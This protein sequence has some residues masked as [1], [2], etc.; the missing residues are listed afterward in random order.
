MHTASY[1]VSKE[2]GKVHCTLCP[3]ACVVV[4]G[5]YGK[6]RVRKNEDGVMLAESWGAVSGYHMDPIEK[7]PLYH[8][9]PGSQI[10]SVGSYGC[11]FRCPWCQNAGISQCGAET[12]MMRRELLPDEIIHT[13]ASSDSMGVA[14][15][16]NE[17]TVWF[18]FM[19]DIARPVKER[20]MKNVVV[21]NGF[22]NPAP[23]DE[24]LEVSDAFNV[25]LKSFD[26]EVYREYAKARLE[27]VLNTL[28]T[29]VAAGKHL[30]V[31]FL[32]VPGVNDDLERFEEMIKWLK[33][34][35]GKKVVLHVN[36]Y[37]PSWKMHAAPTPVKLMRRMKSIAGAHL[38]H[39]YLGNVPGEA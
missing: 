16:Y 7:K 14:Y 11:N 27:P 6:C 38:P 30:E 3:H 13:A 23:L 1:F 36:R 21:T 32:V 17:P 26:D 28:K 31:T 9:Y 22:I 25:D 19:M 39:V 2:G 18:E 29:I 8:Y 4:H 5:G 24:M 33:A 15:T 37:Y 34:E 10:L 12:G 35:A 20:G